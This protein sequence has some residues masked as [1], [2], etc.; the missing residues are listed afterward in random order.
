MKTKI[1]KIL[2]TV[3]LAIYFI[4][5]YWFLSQ[6]TEHPLAVILAML[7]SI[8]FMIVTHE[9][10]HL[11]FGLLTGYR[12]V[13]FRV[14]SFMLVKAEGKWAIR[15]MSIPGTGGQCL[16][17]PPRK[18]NG[19]FPFVLYNLGGILFCGVLSLIP[20]IVG[21]SGESLDLR[22]ILFIFG[23]VSFVMNLMNAIPTNGKSMIND[24]TNLKM[25]LKSEV[26]QSALWNQLEYVALHAQ[27]IRTA[28]MP[29]DLFFLP[30]KEE[31]SN[32]LIF[33]QI[34]AAVERAEDTGDYERAREIAFS[35]LDHA[36]S[37]A[38]LYKG[39]LQIEAVYLGSLLGK[40]ADG[41]LSDRT[42]EYLESIQKT[43][44]FRTFASFHRATYAYRLLIKRDTA[45]AE[46]ALAELRLK[47]KKAPYRAEAEFEQNQLDYINKQYANYQ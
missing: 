43:P 34:L 2:S 36:K 11:I 26:A 4:A 25:A 27:N 46:K 30:E 45:N 14:F 5:I 40:E 29:D 28:D 15:R 6:T 10:G 22:M 12:F 33:W 20:I 47:I 18:K 23:F 13:S 44:A 24:A 41:S 9:L 19:K 42:D 3:L 21:L 17:A 37:V 38:P 7:A 8:L 39:V 35:A 32:P 1:K 31:L 16:M